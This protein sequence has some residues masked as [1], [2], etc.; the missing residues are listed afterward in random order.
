MLN[1]A[2][3]VLLVDDD[4]V[5][6][7]MVSSHLERLRVEKIRQVEDRRTAL[8]E[9]DHQ[10]PDVVIPDGGRPRVNGLHNHPK[11]FGNM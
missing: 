5:L 10:K 4:P 8:E 11:L 6:H 9:I 1:P 2:L 3:D 7:S